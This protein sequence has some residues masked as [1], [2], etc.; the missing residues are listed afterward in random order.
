MNFL[1]VL[2]YPGQNLQKNTVPFTYI[3]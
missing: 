2:S 1:I 3:F